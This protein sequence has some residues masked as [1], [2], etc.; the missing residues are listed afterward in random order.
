MRPAAPGSP[1]LQHLTS[2]WYNKTLLPG[3]GPG[4]TPVF[5]EQQHDHVLC[6]LKADS[7]EVGW[8]EPVI[9]S[10]SALTPGTT[11][12]DPTKATLVPE[13]IKPTDEPGAWGIAQSI[14][15]PGCVGTVAAAG[16][17]W[18][19]FTRTNTNH[20]YVDLTGDSLTS[21]YSGPARIISFTATSGNEGYGLILLNFSTPEGDT[22]YDYLLI[23]EWLG[24]IALARKR[25][26]DM[27]DLNQIVI[28]RD[29]RGIFSYQRVGNGG[30][31]FHQPAVDK[32]YAVQANCQNTPTLPTDP[33]GACCYQSSSG[34][35]CFESTQADCTAFGGVWKGEGTTCVEDGCP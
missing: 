35:D 19:K 13:I 15:A 3:K 12:T 26:M 11:A 22:H 16:I 18:A 23:T 1:I 34:W 32:Y 24:G 5:G 25:T 31:M 8:F 20:K 29:P 14:I 17:T 4:T 10:G 9:F 2:K 28:V 30:I 21:T 33:V 6:F 27:V 7:T